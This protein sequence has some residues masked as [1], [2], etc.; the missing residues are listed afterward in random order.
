MMPT[1]DWSRLHSGEW[2]AFHV[3]WI[4]S[5]ARALNGGRLPEGFYALPEQRS[6]EDPVDGGKE[7]RHEPDV[8]TLERADAPWASATDDGGVAVAEPETTLLGDVELDAAYAAMRR[9]IVIRHVSDDRPVAMLEIASP[10]NK[11]SKSAVNSFVAKCTGW[12]KSG[13]HVAIIDLFP[14]RSFDPFGLG[15]TVA[16]ANGVGAIEERVP[17]VSF[18]AGPRLRTFGD[19]FAIGDEIPPLPLF[20]ARRRH[21]MLP[22][23]ETYDD[24]FV[25]VPK[26]LRERLQAPG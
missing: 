23:Q 17:G 14:P 4:G 13:L 8:L 15:V 10:G 25:G 12:L 24:A 6:L 16:E 5:L 1:H 19:M 21:V 20:Y 9:T 7:K 22:L 2:H 3:W 26:H 18:E 11:E